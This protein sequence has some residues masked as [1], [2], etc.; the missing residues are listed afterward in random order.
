MLTQFR[1]DEQPPGPGAEVVISVQR[2]PDVTVISATGSVDVALLAD[3]ANAARLIRAEGP[4][5]LDLSAVDWLDHASAALAAIWSKTGIDHGAVAVTRV[6]L[7]ALTS[8]G[9]IQEMP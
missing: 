2:D 9:A 7:P 1:R 6:R 8:S 5:I 3:L 4:V